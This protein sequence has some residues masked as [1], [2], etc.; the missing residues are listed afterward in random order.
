[1]TTESVYKDA[2]LHEV[3]MAIHFTPISSLGTIGLV[4]RCA[5]LSEFWGGYA[6]KEM[7][8]VPTRVEPERLSSTGSPTLSINQ[9]PIEIGCMLTSPDQSVVVSIQ[10]NRFDI[11]WR[12]QDG[13][14][15]PRYVRLRSRLL[16]K[17]K[18]FCDAVP[19]LGVLTP[20][21]TQGGIQYINIVDDSNGHGHTYFKLFDLSDFQQYEGLAFQTSQR[22]SGSGEVGRLYLEVNTIN[23]VSIAPNNDLVDERKLQ[24]A[25]T[26]RGQPRTNSLDGVMRLIDRGHEAIIKT[27]YK[28]C[29]SIGLKQ[30]GHEEVNV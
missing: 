2:P 26:F 21:V 17:F 7:Q 15:Y 10:N 6:I 23:V 3:S 5:A 1:M 27:F 16:E 12:K 19:A 13:E 20:N 4:A 24:L 30:F 11:V 9:G 25:I 8:K 29:S 28:S 14:E 18:E 22:L